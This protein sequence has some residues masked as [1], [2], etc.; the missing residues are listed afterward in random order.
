MSQNISKYNDKLD[1][2]LEDFNNREYDAFGSVY[3]LMYK[4]LYYL[5]NSIYKN[6]TI[7]P[8]DIIQDIFI[9]IWQKD[10]CKFDSIHK[11]RTYIHISI[12]NGYKV[13]Y[14]H[15][16]LKNLVN[17]EIALDNDYFTIK[18]AEAEI[19]SII[20]DILKLLPQECAKTFELFLKGYNVEE[21]CEKLNKKPTTVYNQK[22]EAINILRNKLD[23]GKFI[24][25]ILIFAKF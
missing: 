18:S 21:I 19:Y 4:E 20:P 10:S 16:K 5:T 3:S 7:D 6:T 8:K 12:R 17:K 22:K 13:Y 24:S 1:T 14:N 23:K 25:L 11:L 9:S 2:L 15:S